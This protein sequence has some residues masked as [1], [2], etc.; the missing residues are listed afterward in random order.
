MNGIGIAFAYAK[1][2]LLRKG[3]KF[4]RSGHPVFLVDLFRS[5]GYIGENISLLG[6]P[7]H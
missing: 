2:A 5:R 1:G 6:W 7:D 4:R 3:R